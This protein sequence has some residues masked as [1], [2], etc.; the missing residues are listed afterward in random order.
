MN[1][2]DNSAQNSCKHRTN[3]C[4]PLCVCI[5]Y[6]LIHI[7]HGLIP[8]DTLPYPSIPSWNHCGGT[9]I[10]LDGK[11]SINQWHQLYFTTCEKFHCSIKTT[12]LKSLSQPLIPQI[13]YR[14]PL[15]E[16]NFHFS[17]DR[18]MMSLYSFISSVLS[19]FW[20]GIIIGFSGLAVNG[21]GGLIYYTDS[22]SRAA[23]F[24]KRAI[25]ILICRK[26][27]V[28]KLQWLHSTRILQK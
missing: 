18:E 25:R 21:I 1:K 4:I 7:C 13:N 11:S 2:Y 5:F 19:F 23:E 14:T 3:S 6:E 16:R 27:Q 22:F 20:A 8:S 9:Q 26:V 15:L 17:E 28:R 10:N 12:L 24:P